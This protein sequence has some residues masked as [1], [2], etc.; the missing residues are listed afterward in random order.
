MEKTE[1]DQIQKLLTENRDFLCQT[2]AGLTAEQRGFKPAPD[3]W[4]VADCIEHSTLVET[5]V[6][7]NIQTLIQSPPPAERPE[8]GGKDQVIL[9]QVPKRV[10]RIQGPA[11]LMPTGQC[12]DSDQLLRDFESARELTLQFAAE[13][14]TDLRAYASPHPVLGPLDCY[15]WL[16]AI[17]SHCQRHVHQME[18]IKANA[19]FPASAGS[20]QA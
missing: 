8:T 3:R 13:T 11:A 7:K 1:R 12:L 18:E 10:T 4:S 16:L 20:A 17:A 5:R 2:V 9:E 14:Q 6:L 15:Q 19:A